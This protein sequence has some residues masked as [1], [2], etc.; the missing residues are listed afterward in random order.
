MIRNSLI[1]GKSN[2]VGE[3]QP[4]A[5]VTERRAKPPEA[6]V[7]RAMRC[8]SA[9]Q[10][11]ANAPTR[12]GGRNAMASGPDP[13]VPADLGVRAGVGDSTHKSGG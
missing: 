7:M 6:G 5:K 10:F 11:R 9:R 2:F 1:A 4:E 8:D 12:M 13:R 3:T